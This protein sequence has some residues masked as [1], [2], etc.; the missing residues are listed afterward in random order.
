MSMQAVTQGSG[1]I[2]GLL[3]GVLALVFLVLLAVVPAGAEE[4][5][6]GVTPG[7]EPNVTVP[8]TVVPETTITPLETA[9]ETLVETPVETTPAAAV[10]TTTEAT[11]PTPDEDIPLDIM[12]AGILAA[13]PTGITISV[14]PAI[15]IFGGTSGM[16]VPGSYQS[17]VTVTVQARGIPNWYLRAGDTSPGTPSKGFLYC[18]ASTR[19]LT[20]PLKIWDFTLATPGFRDLGS[21][22]TIFYSS[23]KPG[24]TTVDARFMQNT[25]TKDRACTYSM[26]V[27]FTGTTS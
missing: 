5:G 6:A 16:R 8:V 21:G 18:T 22:N 1:V 25:T 4:M 3:P 11:V 14:N 15:A 7:V 23:T 2:P 24:K 9:T 19:N 20:S 26:I 27:T 12:E 17:P 13:P 10:T